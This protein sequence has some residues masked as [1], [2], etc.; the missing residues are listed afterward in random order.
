MTK[1]IRNLNALKWEKTFLRQFHFTMVIYNCFFPTANFASRSAI[2]GVRLNV[3]FPKEL[4]SFPKKKLFY[5]HV[6]MK[7]DWISFLFFSACRISTGKFQS[8]IVSE[9]LW[10]RH[11]QFDNDR[12]PATSLPFAGQNQWMFYKLHA[13]KANHCQFVNGFGALA[14]KPAWIS[15]MDTKNISSSTS[16][17]DKNM[18][19]IDC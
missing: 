3:C 10:Y 12:L 4:K 15:A 19:L 16:F 2:R 14:V 9:R 17:L 13:G 7:S 6:D 1:N 8:G 18:K 11:W 5:K